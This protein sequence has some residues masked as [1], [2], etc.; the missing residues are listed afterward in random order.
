MSNLIKPSSYIS[1]EEMRLIEIMQKERRMGKKAQAAKDETGSED[2]SGNEQLEQEQQRIMNE[3][4]QLANQIIQ[5]ATA[6]ADRIRAEANAEI[7]KWWDERRKEDAAAAEQARLKAEEQG[8]REGW[9]NAEQAARE[10]YAGLIREAKDVLTLAQQ[11]RKEMILEA[12]PFLV[13]LSCAIAEKIIRRELSVGDDW[14]KE[15][16]QTY[17]R[18]ERDKKTIII[19]VNPKQFASL[20]AVREEFALAVG[21][22]SELRIVPDAAVT[23]NGVMISTPFG[24]VDA[25]ID[26]QL[27]EIRQALLTIAHDAPNEFLESGGDA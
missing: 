3:A 4:N 11:M 12:E 8:Y 5:D 19:A 15:T 22:Q 25:R 26:T 1:L 13:E 24:S 10:Q 18:E 14:L 2:K 23:E 17:L 21:S 16:I 7:R 6:E 9:N 20:A 27:M